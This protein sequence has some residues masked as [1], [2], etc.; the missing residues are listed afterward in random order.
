MSLNDVQRNL[1]WALESLEIL[2]AS[3]S[4]SQV[5]LSIGNAMCTGRNDPNY[6]Y[7]SLS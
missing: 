4:W 2:D 1:Y 6:T 3:A 7:I 5:K